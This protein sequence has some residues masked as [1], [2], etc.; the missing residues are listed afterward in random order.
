MNII[1][2]LKDNGAGL[3]GQISMFL[4]VIVISLFI[5][6]RVERK[7]FPKNPKL[8][9]LSKIASK[10]HPYAAML[11]FITAGVHGYMELG[12]EIMFHS[13]Y[14]AY[15]FLITSGI[16]IFIWKK[17]KNKKWL[18]AHR[19]SALLFALALAYHMIG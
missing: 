7:F 19:V 6:R 2:Y 8:M 4:A 15:F 5:L 12:G 14:L 16:T 17:I 1:S 3:T 13:G 9:K 18:I 11:M 10:L